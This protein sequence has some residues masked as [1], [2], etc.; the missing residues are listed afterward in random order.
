VTGAEFLQAFVWQD[1]V[2]AFGSF[3]GIATKLYALWDSRTSWSRRSSGVNVVF[4]PP[5]L[6]A[7]YTLGLW[8]TF[9]TTFLNMSIWFGIYVFRP[10]EC[11]DWIGRRNGETYLF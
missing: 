4:Y 2:L 10:P 11:E 3:I 6:I 9:V 7:F 8:L 5:S 1:A